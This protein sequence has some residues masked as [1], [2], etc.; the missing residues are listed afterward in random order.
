VERG[1]LSR[2]QS[3]EIVQRAALAAA[4]ERRPLRELLALEPAVAQS[5]GLAD[6]DACFD[7]ARH[8]GHVPTVIARLDVVDAATARPATE[9]AR[10][11][12]SARKEPVDAHR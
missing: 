8:L 2:E 12:D 11:R 1:G 7:D 4:D 3:Y 6:L 10:E 5:L 9:P